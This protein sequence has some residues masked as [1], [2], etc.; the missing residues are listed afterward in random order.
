M[1]ISIY[2]TASLK[3]QIRVLK[4]HERFLQETKIKEKER[5]TLFCGNFTVF[6]SNKE[7]ICVCYSLKV[8]LYTC[9]VPQFF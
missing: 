9:H 5:K 4:P 8:Y 3:N 7:H 6:C 2:K 1:K